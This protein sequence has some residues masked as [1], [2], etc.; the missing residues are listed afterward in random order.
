[1][2]NVILHYRK[3]HCLNCGIKVEKTGLTSPGGHRVT[4]RLTQYTHELCQH[5]T[6]KELVEHLNLHRETV[7]EIDQKFLKKEFGETN[8]SHS[9]LIT[10]DEVSFAKHHR[11]L[12]V[13]LDFKTGRVIWL[14]KERKADT[15]NDFF[16]KMPQKKLKQIKTITMDM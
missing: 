16:E 5:M 9:G 10:M 6:V 12:I 13:V 8:H 3:I 14:G 11:H 7:K 15:L 4:N 1:M 2:L